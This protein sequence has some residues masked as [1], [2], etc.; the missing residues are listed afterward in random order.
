MIQDAEAPSDVV[1]ART[2][3]K[4][5]S[6]T[7]VF[8]VVP[9]GTDDAGGGFRV[10]TN[11]AG[12]TG[13]TAPPSHTAL[14]MRSCAYQASLEPGSLTCKDSNGKSCKAVLTRR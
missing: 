14:V 13:Q 9:P 4:A 3:T 11:D 6:D 5:P 2:D 7:G 12:A 8:V 10:L 1:D